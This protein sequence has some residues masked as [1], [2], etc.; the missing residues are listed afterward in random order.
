MNITRLESIRKQLENERS[1][2]CQ[3]LN[4]A[5]DQ[6]H[7]DNF[8]REKAEIA[9]QTQERD[10]LLVLTGKLREQ[11]LEIEHALHKLEEG[12]YGICDSCGQPIESGR[13]EV[14]PHASQ[15]MGC[16]AT[17]KKMNKD[18]TGHNG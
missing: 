11:M 7:G 4:T 13:L 14:L 16:K 1:R 9:M 5:E 2:L 18:F 6:R 3:D 8:S 17:N 15:C 10:K 12:S